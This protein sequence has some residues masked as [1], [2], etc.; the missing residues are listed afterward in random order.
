[1]GGRD[2]EGA[3][4]WHRNLKRCACD[5]AAHG[6]VVVVEVVDVPRHRGDSR[7][8][9]VAAV[10][11]ADAVAPDDV[12]PRLHHHLQFMRGAGA[13][14]EEV[15][16]VH[17]TDSVCPRLVC[18]K[19]NPVPVPVVEERQ[20]GRRC[21]CP[22]ISC[23]PEDGQGEFRR[24]AHTKLRGPFYV[25]AVVYHGDAL[26]H[27]RRTHLLAAQHPVEAEHPVAV[28][29]MVPLHCRRVGVLPVE[30]RPPL[31]MP[32][33]LH[34]FG[35]KGRVGNHVAFAHGAV[36]GKLEC[37]AVNNFNAYI[38]LIVATAVVVY[39]VHDVVVHRHIVDCIVRRRRRCLL[40][41][42][43]VVAGDVAWPRGRA[44]EELHF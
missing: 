6:C 14:V 37:G 31:D 44:V 30:Q 22:F 23:R 33:V 9:Q 16:P 20:A 35:Q 15:A 39:A 2:Q 17:R 3:L 4:V 21:D 43:P 18:D 8:V 27:K 38:F 5:G 1:M 12:E 29:R 13:A 41:T 7:G 19:D 11:Q 40:A 28:V 34:A 26:V 24:L 42:P 10:R 36:A 25:Q 32:I